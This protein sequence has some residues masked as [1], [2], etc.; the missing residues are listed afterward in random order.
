[1]SLESIFEEHRSLLFSIAYRML[2]SAMEAEDM[3][4]ETYLRFM[5]TD[6]ESIRSP[7]SYLST[8]ITRLCLDTLKSAKTQREAYIGPWLPEPMLTE[9]P[10]APTDERTPDH[11]LSRYEDISLAFLTMLESLSPVER[12]V[13]LLRE[14]FDYDYDEIAKVVE[15]SPANC[16]QLY[17]RARQ[18]IEAGKA[19]FSPPPEK[20]EQMLA[21]FFS[22]IDSGDLEG[23]QS[24]LAQDVM[25]WSDGGGKVAAA[26]RPLS[27]TEAIARFLIGINQRAPDGVTRTFNRING[28]PAAL[29][30]YQGQIRVVVTFSADEDHILALRLIGNP[31][32]LRY[33][34][35]QLADQQ[36]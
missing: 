34:Q 35:R 20:Q 5:G 14:V 18:H 32:K 12:A 31:D 27:G 29:V 15:K 8:V 19:R 6:P 26:T 17:S 33:L 30:W 1:M 11:L 36:K 23:L 22:A 3:V 25:L 16:R 9:G 7:R 28:A 10:L 2:G 24:M 21:Q 13:F 4:Q